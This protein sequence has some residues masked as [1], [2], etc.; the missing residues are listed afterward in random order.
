[1]SV[2]ISVATRGKPS[3]KRNSGKGERIFCPQHPYT[4]KSGYVMRSHLIWE[5]T[6]HHLLHSWFVIHHINGIHT[7][8][9]PENLAPMF[10]REHNRYHCWTR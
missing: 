6:H 10:K 4:N 5:F 3:W 9:R 2:I 1:V 7:D 8:D